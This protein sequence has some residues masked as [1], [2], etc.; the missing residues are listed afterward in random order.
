MALDQAD[1]DIAALAP[2][3]MPLAEH[4]VGLAHA[5]RGAEEDFEPATAVPG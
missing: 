5:G 4:R 3:A 1:H 2:E